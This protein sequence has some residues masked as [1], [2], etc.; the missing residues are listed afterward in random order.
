MS[1]RSISAV[2]ILVAAGVL[3]GCRDGGWQGARP[4]PGVVSAAEVARGG[5]LFLRSCAACHGRLGQGIRGL[6][7]DLRGNAFVASRPDADLVRFLEVGRRASDPGN[8]TRI[9]MPPRGGNPG[10]T[11][12]DLAAIV[13][14]LRALERP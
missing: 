3:A 8:K 2:L 11:D 12:A 13:A 4:A 6:G 9:D 1:P 7:P 10:L 14:W 5:T